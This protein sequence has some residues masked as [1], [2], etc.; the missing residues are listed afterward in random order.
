MKSLKAKFRKSD[1]N[2]WNKNDERLLQAVENGDSERVASLLGKKGVGATKLDGEGKTAFHLAAIKGHAEVLQHMLSHGVDITAPDAAGHSALHLAAKNA[3]P[4]CVKKLLQFKCPAE[5]TDSTGKTALHHAAASGCLP[6]VQ[7]LCEHKCPLNVKDTDGSTPLHLAVQNGHIE[8]CRYLMD[9]SIDIDSTDKKGRTALML[10]CETGAISIVDLC[11]RKGADVKLIDALGRDALHYSKLSDN[12]DIHTLLLLNISPDA[13]VKTPTKPKQMGDLSS[14]Q[15]ATSTPASGKGGAFFTEQLLKEDDGYVQQEKDR[16]SDS[17]GVDS[18]LD[19]SSEVEP[20]NV[21]SVLQAKIALL[22]LRNKELESK[23]Q[24]KALNDSGMDIGKESLLCQAA[25]KTKQP[26]SSDTDSPVVTADVSTETEPQYHMES[27]SEVEVKQ[28]SEALQELQIQLERSEVER[29]HLESQLKVA[30]EG[31]IVIDHKEIPE[32]K[33]EQVD[34]LPCKTESPSREILNAQVVCSLGAEN[35]DGNTG[36]AEQ[37]APVEELNLLRQGYEKAQA[38]SEINK[39]IVIQLENELSKMEE[40]L[41]SMMSKDEQEEMKNS[42]SL[43]IE[44]INQE[45]VLLIKKYEDGQEEIRKL[46][47]SVKDLNSSTHEAAELKRAMEKT[48]EELRKEMSELSLLYKESQSELDDYRRLPAANTDSNFISKEE[49]EHIILELKDLRVKAEDEVMEME[50]EYERALHE[51]VALKQQLEVEQEKSVLI[52][53]NAQTIDTLRNTIVELEAERTDLNEQLVDKDFELT[54]LQEQLLAEKAVSR[55]AVAA[56]ESSE[57]C[58]LSL[59]KEVNV[60]SCKLKD[61]LKEKEK[62]SMDIVQVKNEMLQ[63]KGEK[64][65]LQSLLKSKEQEVADLCLKNSQIQEDLTEMKKCSESSS[66]LEEDKD[67]KISELSKE[68]TKLKDALNSLSQLSFSTCTSKRQGQQLESLQQQV[69]QLQS[70]IIESKKQHQEVVS[71]YRKHLLYAVQ[72][73]MDE[74]VQKVLKQILTMCKSQTQ[75][76]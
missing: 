75:K 67:R 60:L 74:D 50:V 24:E 12:A 20:Q 22:T 59:E 71:I 19:A 66:K 39:Q 10:A 14:P 35:K 3:H 16:M 23:L 43:L 7:L 73:Q 26:N 30:L 13:D 42:Y 55:E 15:S 36:E 49:H 29:K 33:S 41:A 6:I 63:V 46:Q 1:T 61:S 51:L 34:T 17:A 5:C 2:E 28:L 70:Q 76:K 65:V 8:V 37:Q 11:V 58:K 68:V 44:N 9:Q 18:L 32:G 52:A 72:G 56:R 45:K 31:D 48:I 38:E 40:R 47:D 4:E 69:K 62:V 53:E 64:E 21:L 57:K 25:E 54:K 27:Q